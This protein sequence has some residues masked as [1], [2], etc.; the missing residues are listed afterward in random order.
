MTNYH[1]SFIVPTHQIIMDK[2]ILRFDI[3]T[4]P[5]YSLEK[6][7]PADLLAVWG[8]RY[9]SDKP[10][11][12]SDFDR[13]FQRS[14]LFAEFSR[15]V[16]ISLG[17]E[18]DVQEDPTTAWGLHHPG[19]SSKLQLTS[20]VWDEIDIFEQFRWMLSKF[21]WYVLWGHNI[22]NFDMPYLAK[23]FVINGMVVPE[24]LDN[25][26]K[27]PR[28]IPVID[29]MEHRKM[30]GGASTWLETICI[31]LGVPTPKDAMDWSM[32][33][34]AFYD[35]KIAD[36]LLYCEKDVEAVYRCWKRMNRQQD[37][38]DWDDDLLLVSD[39]FIGTRWFEKIT[40]I[41]YGKDMTNSQ[42]KRFNKLLRQYDADH[43]QR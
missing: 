22:K 25:S 34:R 16:C 6:D 36:I 31:V 4:S 28:E 33:G 1:S 42:K 14:P 5:L 19:V 37:M 39:A 7:M 17:Y 30:W 43:N 41:K 13:F 32:V 38:V 27:K 20:L 8:K 11:D 40:G 29:T 15:V 12:L 10:D 23:R 24:L 26:W 3:E 21:P 9:C 2:K 18:K 35:G